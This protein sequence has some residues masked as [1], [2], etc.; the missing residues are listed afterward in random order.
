[1]MHFLTSGIR[2]RRQ[3]HNTDWPTPLGPCCR[4]VLLRGLQQSWGMCSNTCMGLL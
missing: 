1:M 2:C 4:D 3:S